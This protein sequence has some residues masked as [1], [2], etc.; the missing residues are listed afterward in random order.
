MPIKFVPGSTVTNG[1][2]TSGGYTGQRE[3]DGTIKLIHPNTIVM[4][5]WSE[6]IP[7]VSGNIPFINVGGV[8]VP[9]PIEGTIYTFAPPSGGLTANVLMVAGGG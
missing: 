6:T 9:S 8:G 4:A 3:S 1:S 7:F 2:W 5:V